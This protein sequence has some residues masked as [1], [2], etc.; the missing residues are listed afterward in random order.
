MFVQFVCRLIF[1]NIMDKLEWLLVGEWMREQMVNFFLIL[2][3]C[4]WEQVLLD[5]TKLDI[6]RSCTLDSPNYPSSNILNIPNIT[7]KN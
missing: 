7:L 6:G 2:L 3:L 4:F 1:A 5:L